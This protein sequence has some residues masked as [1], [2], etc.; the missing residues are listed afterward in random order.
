MLAM[1]WTDM[2]KRRYDNAVLENAILTN[3]YFLLDLI[4]N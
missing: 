4:N 2:D 3:K 1:V